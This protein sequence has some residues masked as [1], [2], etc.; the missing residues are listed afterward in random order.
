MHTHSPLEYH[1][2]EYLGEDP[3]AVQNPKNP[4]TLLRHG[5]IAQEWLIKAYLGAWLEL[6][7]GLVDASYPLALRYRAQFRALA[8]LGERLDPSLP[9]AEQVSFLMGAQHH[10][11]STLRSMAECPSER[12]MQWGLWGRD[13]PVAIAFGFTDTE[14]L[15]PLVCESIGQCC[16]Y[17]ALLVSQVVTDDGVAE[18]I[19]GQMFEAKPRALLELLKTIPDAPEA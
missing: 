12:D 15:S 2:L 17:A 7:G 10:L 1:L 14:I 19:V 4:T 8:R 11:Q 5:Q 6:I 18:E 13:I 9:P 3:F 16:M